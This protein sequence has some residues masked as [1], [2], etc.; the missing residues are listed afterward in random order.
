MGD[1]ILV[2]TLGLSV[3]SDNVK[4]RFSNKN[5]I[6]CDNNRCKTCR[7][8]LSQD[9]IIGNSNS[10]QHNLN[11]SQPASCTTKNVIYLISCKKCK[12]QYVGLT[13]QA[14]RARLNAHRSAI[15]LKKLKTPLVTHFLLPDHNFSDLKI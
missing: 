8:S 6:Y 1:M 12:I 9:P 15:N 11:F 5:I 10:Y 3:V 13:S 2:L 7:I 14:L 4:F